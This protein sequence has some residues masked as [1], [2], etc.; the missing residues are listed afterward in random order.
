MSTGKLR[1]Q[2]GSNAAAWWLLSMAVAS[3]SMALD[4][5]PTRVNPT[6]R[7]LRAIA[8][9]RLDPAAVIE[10]ITECSTPRSQC[11]EDWQE[12]LTLVLSRYSGE[13]VRQR[14]LVLG[15]LTPRGSMAPDVEAVIRSMADNVSNANPVD[16]PGSIQAKA[17]QSTLT[18]YSGLGPPSR[19]D[20]SRIPYFELRGRMLAYVV[21]VAPRGVSDRI[22]AAIEAAATDDCSRQYHGVA[23][24]VCREVGADW[25]RIASLEMVSLELENSE[26]RP[27]VLGALLD[28]DPR[29][30]RAAIEWGQI[31]GGE[32]LAASLALLDRWTRARP[33]CWEAWADIEDALRSYPAESIADVSDP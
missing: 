22:S 18:R 28:A 32:D 29:A 33:T 8:A 26:G 14:R 5:R 6:V 17:R 2:L 16:T 30:L 4:V 10:G 23:E 7:V 15:A 31:N 19:E 24:T 3:V 11:V 20:L 13:G 1:A 21:G 12:R 27:E 25:I 9:D